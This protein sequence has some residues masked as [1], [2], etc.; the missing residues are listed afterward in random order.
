MGPCGLGR[1]LRHV[2]NLM[3]ID[4]VVCCSQRLTVTHAPLPD[5]ICGC[6][7]MP[8]VSMLAVAMPQMTTALSILTYAASS[9][10]YSL[11]QKPC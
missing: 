2:H 9:L 11:Q 1:T 6:A 5:L 3:S 10:L 7:C 8:S 4:V